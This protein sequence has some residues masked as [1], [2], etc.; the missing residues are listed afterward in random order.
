MTY[1]ELK[2]KAR[3]INENVVVKITNG[4]NEL[5]DTDIVATGY[6][7]EFAEESGSSYYTIILRGDINGD[8]NV[9]IMDLLLI[10]KDILDL[11]ELSGS[12]L[13]AALMEN[14]TE[15]SLMG[16]LLIKKHI[17]GLQSIPQ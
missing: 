11:S 17:L 12:A 5:A 3:D 8:G 6:K 15:V 4:D 1:G 10:K 2:A 9:N 14:D 13:K 16:Y 7:I